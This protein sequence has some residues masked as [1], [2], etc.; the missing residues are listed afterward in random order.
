MNSYGFGFK[1]DS[2]A[3]KFNMGVLKFICGPEY[4]EEDWAGGGGKRVEGRGVGEKDEKRSFRGA[5]TAQERD[6]VV[7]VD[8]FVGQVEGSAAIAAA[9]QVGDNSNASSRGKNVEPLA[10]LR[11]YIRPN[12]DQKFANV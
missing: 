8:S 1:I 4:R 3:S 12:F 9:Q 11:R 10:V 2:L 7:S 6:N 5:D